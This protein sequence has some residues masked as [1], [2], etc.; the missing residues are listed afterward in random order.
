MEKATGPAS[1]RSAE[2]DDRFERGIS[3][4]G[5]QQIADSD[6]CIDPSSGAERSVAE[7][8][9]FV[10]AHSTLPPGWTLQMHPD[11][12]DPS[13]QL[14]QGRV[15]WDAWK[16]DYP[17]APESARHSRL[18]KYI[19][20]CGEEH[21]NSA[22]DGTTT[23]FHMLQ[24]KD[25]ESAATGE[26]LTG[27]TTHICSF[28]RQ[29]SFKRIVAAISDS[30]ADV[31]EAYLFLDDLCDGSHDTPAGWHMP[32]DAD[33]HETAA[34]FAR[35]KQ[36]I[37]SVQGLVQ[38]CS[39]WNNPERLSRAWMLLEMVMAVVTGTP[40]IYAMVAE[41]RH[42]MASALGRPENDWR[43][44]DADANRKL[45]DGWERWEHDGNPYEGD[46]HEIAVNTTYSVDFVSM[47]QFVAADRTRRRRVKREPGAGVEEWQWFWQA[48]GG[49][50]E[51]LDIVMQM[52]INEDAVHTSK[53]NDAS[54]I[55][56]AIRSIA[57]ETCDRGAKSTPGSALRSLEERLANS[58]RKAYAAVV[59]QEFETSWSET[60]SEHPAGVLDLGHQLAVLWSLTDDQQH[61]ENLL[62]RVLGDLMTK[63][64]NWSE[65]KVARRDRTAAALTQL[66]LH[67]STATGE[68]PATTWETMERVHNVQ[69]EALGGD[70][71]VSF[72]GV[73]VAFLLEFS[74]EHNER[75]NFLS[76][77][78]VVERIIKPESNR[79][80]VVGLGKDLQHPPPG[81]AYIETL[82]EDWRGPP[83]FF[84]SHAWRQTFHVA[85]CEWR[86]G[87]IQA[88]VQS[89]RCEAC[90]TDEQSTPTECQDC[91][92]KR[93]TTFVWFDIFCVNQHLRSPQPGEGLQAFA[94]DPL[95]NAIVT[96]EHVE[97]FLETWDDP[98][99]LSRV[100]CLEEL[101]VAILMGKKVRITMPH[102]AMTSFRAR[103]K[104]NARLMVQDIEMVLD[105]ISI[106]HASAT[107]PEDRNFVFANVDDSVGRDNLNRF[108]KEIMR[109]AL[110]SAAFPDG[111]PDDLGGRIKSRDAEWANIFSGILQI[112]DKENTST[113]R[114]IEIRRAVALMRLLRQP[115]DPTGAQELRDVARLAQRYYGP[116]AHEVEDIK[117]QLSSTSSASS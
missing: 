106:E 65:G 94:F 105:R 90:K 15:P 61:A 21:L 92:Q 20:P 116:K 70:L 22:P 24:Q 71:A 64:A 108:A 13:A 100:W 107:F 30:L 38:V 113:S 46:A 93:R 27:K 79:A 69:K 102:G 111:V 6:D 114:E 87:A 3:L 9:S 83:T 8:W 99:T 7:M 97:M 2:D 37:A 67:S 36:A 11:P 88:L 103:A 85:G 5:L 29:M 109:K 75:L 110:T 32:S 56:A 1:K 68:D 63:P 28:P 57:D 112:A 17:D 104:K 44:Y 101:R 14:G 18:Y 48:G 52:Q 51:I 117:R 39:Q 35:K 72:Q 76:T 49:P 33:A 58:T 84:L 26:N 43:E 45:N 54:I 95:R 86:G 66:L 55:L 40:L 60:D 53:P 62:R 78:A 81:R 50:K 12:S 31:S 23:M 82:H 42:A 73:S 98:A 77:D 4:A 91:E 47:R 80:S 25:R 10:W 41:E 74:R 59:A 89:A 115:G 34:W 19:S 96:A 16:Q